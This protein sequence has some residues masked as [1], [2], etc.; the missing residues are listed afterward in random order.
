MK[1]IDKSQL[2]ANLLKFL[3]LVELEGEEILVTDG[4][5]PVLR[6]SQWWGRVYKIVG[7]SQRLLVNPPLQITTKIHYNS[8]NSSSL[9]L[10]NCISCHINH[11]GLSGSRE[12]FRNKYDG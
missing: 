10:I 11:F 6:I 1:T 2:K 8:F 9:A 4:T 3:Q 7:L 5:K 12:G